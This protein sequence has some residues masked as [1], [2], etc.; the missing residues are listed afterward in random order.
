MR[1]GSG[2][3]GTNGSIKSVSGAGVADTNGN[4]SCGISGTSGTRGG[5]RKILGGCGIVKGGVSV[6]IDTS[7]GGNIGMNGG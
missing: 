5:G 7:G 1:D 6:G 2:G 4:G 3:S